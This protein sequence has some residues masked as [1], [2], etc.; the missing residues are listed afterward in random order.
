MEGTRLKIVLDIVHGAVWDH[1]R[2]TQAAFMRVAYVPL[3]PQHLRKSRTMS[4]LKLHYEGWLALPVGLRQKLGLKSGDRL[5]AELAGGTIMLRPLGRP[6]P[7]P[8]R[9]DEGEGRPGRAAAAPR[10]GRAKPSPAATR[11]PAAEAAPP[12]TRRSARQ[13]APAILPPALKSRRGRRKVEE[14]G[15]S[16]SGRS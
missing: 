12:A 16:P 5:E 7:P 14:T 11:P 9:P 8:V 1:I 2:R 3:C 4:T 13:A 6:T 10:A 15:E